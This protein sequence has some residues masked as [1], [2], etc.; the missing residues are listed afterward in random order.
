MATVLCHILTEVIYFEIKGK[1]WWLIIIAAEN[2]P[3]FSPEE[4]RL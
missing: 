3:E 4:M 2:G 1:L